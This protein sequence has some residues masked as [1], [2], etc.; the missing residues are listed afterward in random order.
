LPAGEINPGVGLN[1]Q[2]WH[3]GHAGH[4]SIFD[5]KKGLVSGLRENGC[6]D[7]AIGIKS[8]KPL[9]DLWSEPNRPKLSFTHGSD[10]GCP[11]WLDGE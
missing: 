2:P 6:A 8:P 10:D 9:N 7:L 4:D 1:G 5:F 11:V 3:S